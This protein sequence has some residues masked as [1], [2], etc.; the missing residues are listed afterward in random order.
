MWL[1]SNAV[2]LD[3]YESTALF[4]LNA[5][6][7][8]NMI[9]EYCY[10]FFGWAIG[11]PLSTYATGGMGGGGGGGGLSKASPAPR[12]LSLFSSVIITILYDN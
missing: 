10:L 11:Y 1:R 8:V 6:I 12:K 9:F 7:S 2:S 4:S 5:Y 3:G